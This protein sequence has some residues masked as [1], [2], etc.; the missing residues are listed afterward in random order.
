MNAAHARNSQ[1]EP[2]YGYG[3]VPNP[4]LHPYHD[5]AALTQSAY[6]PPQP[7]LPPYPYGGYGA[8]HHKG[9]RRGLQETSS[10]PQSSSSKSAHLNEL[11]TECANAVDVKG[12]ADVLQ[13]S[14]P[15]TAG[16]ATATKDSVACQQESRQGATSKGAP[17]VVCT[18]L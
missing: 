8:P 1:R 18:R 5:Y 17:D 16:T 2:H 15:V 13:T 4:Y 6:G 11:E 3:Y 14:N 10:S 9:R 7:T 12:A